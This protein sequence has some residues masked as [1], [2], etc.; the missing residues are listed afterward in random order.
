ME[1]VPLSQ[2]LQKSRQGW[3]SKPLPLWHVVKA[4]SPVQGECPDEGPL[5]EAWTLMGVRLVEQFLVTLGS[6][7]EEAG[8]GC[9][10]WQ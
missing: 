6:V 3:A 10:P 2:W 9:C 5:T 8:R 4:L 1:E 7:A